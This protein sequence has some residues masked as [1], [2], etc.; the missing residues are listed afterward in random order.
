VLAL[1]VELCSPRVIASRAKRALVAFG[2]S[3]GLLKGRGKNGGE[4]TIDEYI[5]A[6]EEGR[7]AAA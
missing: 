2:L 4:Y 7:G 5:S 1:Q 6:I 3:A